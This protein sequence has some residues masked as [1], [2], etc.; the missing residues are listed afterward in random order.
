MTKFEK[1]N[2]VVHL[3]GL[4]RAAQALQREELREDQLVLFDPVKIEAEE[5]ARQEDARDYAGTGSV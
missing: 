4:A 3:H 5:K 2:P 1:F